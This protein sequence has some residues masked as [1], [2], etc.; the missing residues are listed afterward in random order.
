MSDFN[1]APGLTL[2]P[3]VPVIGGKTERVCPAGDGT[4][5]FVDPAEA[6]AQWA[7]NGARWVH[8][9]DQ[10]AAFRRGN[11]RAAIKRIHKLARSIS[12]QVSGRIVDEDS[13]EAALDSGATRIVLSTAAWENPEWVAN[14]IARLGEQVAVA[15]DVRDNVLASRGWTDGGQNLGSAIERLDA[16]GCCRYVITDV[17][18][19]GTLAGPNLELIREILDHTHR[20]VITAGGIA[21]LDDLAELRELVPRGLEGAIVGRALQRQVFSLAEALDVAGG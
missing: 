1:R 17:T 11:N 20:P 5:T 18:R 2:F 4:K 14:V 15:L 12:V 6:T 10:D 9:V 21:S 3:A 8:V 16:I 7:R 19:D 13:L